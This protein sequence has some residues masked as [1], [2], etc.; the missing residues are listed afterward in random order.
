[1]RLVDIFSLRRS[2]LNRIRGAD[3]ILE[4]TI[5]LCLFP[6]QAACAYYDRSFQ[7]V[8][9]GISSDTVSSARRIGSDDEHV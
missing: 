5:S 4:S 9:G 7:R 8:S 1:M 6:S 3:A 2:G